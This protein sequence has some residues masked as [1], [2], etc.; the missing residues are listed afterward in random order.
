MAQ[1]ALKKVLEKEHPERNEY[2]F[3]SFDMGVTPIEDLV[4]E[5]ELHSLTMDQKVVVAENCFFLDKLG[6]GKRKKKY[7]G[8]E[9]LEE[10]VKNDDPATDLYLLLYT[11]VLDYSNP[12]VA[13]IKEKHRIQSVN[14]LSRDEWIAYYKRSF[15]KNGYVITPD[16]LEELYTRIDGDYAR[17]LNEAA[18]LQAYKGEETKIDEI[19]VSSMV[20]PKLEEDSIKMCNFLTSGDIAGAIKIYKDLKLHSN[21]EMMLIGML[22]TQFIFYDR[23]KYLDSKGYSSDEIAEQLNVKNSKRVFMTL[24]TTRKLTS[25]SISNIMEQLYEAESSI[26]SGIASPEFAF[27]RFLA[28]FSI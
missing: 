4:N 7:E 2:N 9:R 15:E 5:C 25:A 26:L 23:V 10:Y 13:V 1:S 19:D 14:Q 6:E 18:K 16:A 12:I 8:I 20:A 17:F 3:V 24:K 28:N 11:E 22:T 27:S 21:D